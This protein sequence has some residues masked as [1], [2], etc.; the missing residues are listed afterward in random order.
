M[1]ER[2]LIKDIATINTEELKDA[3]SLLKYDLEQDE[4]MYAKWKDARLLEYIEEKRQ[5]IQAI[6]EE[7]R[8]RLRL[9]G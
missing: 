2:K 4:K 9:H 3:L 1:G 5:S 6:K 8:S 7:L